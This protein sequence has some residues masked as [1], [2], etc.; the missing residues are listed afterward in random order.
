MSKTVSQPVKE[1][2][3]PKKA[4][5]DKK[6]DRDDFEK[7][8]SKPARKITKMRIDSDEEDE[9]NYSDDSMLAELAKKGDILEEN[10]DDLPSKRK[11]RGK[12]IKID[13]FHQL[14]DDEG[15]DPPGQSATKSAE[16]DSEFLF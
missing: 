9:Y 14:S 3:K 7:G 11:T 1:A 15:T 16:D 2:E 5:G 10:S 6:R 13:F 8:L 12:R 4:M